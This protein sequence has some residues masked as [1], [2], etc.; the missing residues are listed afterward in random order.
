MNRQRHVLT[1]P[2]LPLVALFFGLLSAADGFHS[3]TLA[4]AAG[5]TYA[6]TFLVFSVWG[7]TGGFQSIR[8][9]S[10]L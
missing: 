7:L 1:R 3:K 9:W 4:L 5:V 8:S 2:L 10:D 6:L